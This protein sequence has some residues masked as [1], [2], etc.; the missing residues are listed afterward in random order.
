[1]RLDQEQKQAIDFALN[2][3]DGEVYL[4]GSRVDDKSRGGDIDILIF[5]KEDSYK[6]SQKVK[7]KFFSQCEEKIDVIVMDP[8]NLS[9]EQQ[10]FLDTV[11]KEKIK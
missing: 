11:D 10:T 9:L 5:S 1:M 2:E 6:L 3:I 7:V 4:F 8:E